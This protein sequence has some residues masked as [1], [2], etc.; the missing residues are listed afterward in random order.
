MGF[1]IGKE[2]KDAVTIKIESGSMNIINKV[3]NHTIECF[4]IQPKGEAD[5]IKIRNL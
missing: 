2:G 1:L 4:I 3:N 5:I